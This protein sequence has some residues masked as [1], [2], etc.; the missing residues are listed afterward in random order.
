MIAIKSQNYFDGPS[1]VYY[2]PDNDELVILEQKSFALI[3]MK[4]NPPTVDTAY[5]YDVHYENEFYPDQ[6]LIDFALI[7]YIG[8]FK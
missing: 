3:P 7:E 4:L 1:G 5:K 2:L 6:I 8:V